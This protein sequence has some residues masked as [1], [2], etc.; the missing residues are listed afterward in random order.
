MNS[1]AYLITLSLA[2]AAWIEAGRLGRFRLEAGTYVYVGSAKRA[3]QARVARHC[4]LATT[5][6]GKRH[7]H[8]DGLLLH[9]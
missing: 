6:Q 4:R 8:I 3:L 1:G 9:R 7:W 5:K 2:R